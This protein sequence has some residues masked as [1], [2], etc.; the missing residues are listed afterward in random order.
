MK[1]YVILSPF[2][3][4]YPHLEKSFLI[5]EVVLKSLVLLFLVLPLLLLS[6]PL[7]ARATLPQT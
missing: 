2:A 1:L 3:T 6:P 4:I 5:L 7:F